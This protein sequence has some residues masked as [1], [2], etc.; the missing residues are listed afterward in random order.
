MIE[1]PWMAEMQGKK[2]NMEHF[3]AQVWDWKSEAVALTHLR[4]A[5]VKSAS[6]SLY[7]MMTCEQST[8]SRAR[9]IKATPLWFLATS[10]LRP[11]DMFW[12]S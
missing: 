3:L 11:L 7:V 2:V 5:A 6:N 4:E 1:H 10:G 8:N 12:M 9:S